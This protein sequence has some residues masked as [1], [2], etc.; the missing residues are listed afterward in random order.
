MSKS[1]PERVPSSPWS[2][3]EPYT[4]LLRALLPRMNSLSVLDPQGTMH[5]SSEMSVPPELST[6][7]AEAVKNAREPGSAGVARSIAGEPFYLF[8][9]NS[10]DPAADAL[11][12]VVVAI[13][14]RQT[15]EGEQRSFAFVHGM[16]KP[17]LECLRRELLARHEI[18][19]LH[20]S[21]AE[22]DDD[23]E[24]LLSV[25][26]GGPD[27]SP[28]S[29]TDLKDIVASATEHL[30]VGLAALII[31]ERGIA[32]VHASVEAPLDTAL[33]AKAHRHLLSMAQMRRGASIV[34]RMVLQ[35]GEADVAYR[36]LA[37]PIARGDGRCVGVLALF[38]AES[39]PE[40]TPHH[41]RLTELLSRRVAAVLAHSYDA[42]TGLL[43]RPAFEQRVRRALERGPAAVGAAT[44]GTAGDWSALFNDIN[45]LHI[46]N[47]NYGMPMG[48]KV[49]AQ[50][51]ELIRKRIPPGSSGARIS[52]DRF[53][54]LLPASL[55][56]AAKFAEALR[57]G[58][59]EIGISLG[60]GK[61][62]VSISVGVA[63]T[64]TRIKEFV[65][66]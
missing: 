44:G 66:A 59:E 28:E 37:C 20:N 10:D 32:V 53:A 46:I 51:G 19:N 50:I 34:N 55:S 61:M 8:W 18:L 7:V 43:T 2:S 41:S 11:P 5:W 58:A 52:G 45:R 21:L 57:A 35:A 64:E 63:A 6:L 56:D 27:A 62:Q 17:A 65:H 31:P 60:D 33:L 48:D 4:Q 29:A 54:I 47:D 36:V 12:L 15:A 16:V 39:S 49:I 3:L 24:M 30:K 9:L 1:P 38:R 23:L 42:I 26:G 14:F 22:Q 25:S 13:G 40:F